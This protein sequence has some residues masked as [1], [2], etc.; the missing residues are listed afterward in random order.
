MTR[1]E[2]NGKEEGEGWQCEGQVASEKSNM[3]ACEGRSMALRR[4]KDL[5]MNVTNCGRKVQRATEN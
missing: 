3:R 2:V 1:R 4:L 5:V